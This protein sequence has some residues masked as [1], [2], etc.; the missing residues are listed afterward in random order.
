ML[1]ELNTSLQIADRRCQVAP[2]EIR[3]A[4]LAVRGRQAERM[5][6]LFRNLHSL[7]RYDFRIAE[8]A[9]LGQRA[10][11]EGADCHGREANLAKAL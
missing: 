5:V 6:G 11:Q 9:K 4:T 8:L 1:R 7:S 2:D 3:I 10:R